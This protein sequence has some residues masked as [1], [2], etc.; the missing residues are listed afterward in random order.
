MASKVIMYTTGCPKCRVLQRKLDAA[1]VEYEEHN[2]MAEM[3]S[4]GLRAAPTL[5]VDGELMDFNK[6]CKWADS[7][8]E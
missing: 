3:L 1:H 4:L 2:D 6:A 8:K 5:S 7:Q